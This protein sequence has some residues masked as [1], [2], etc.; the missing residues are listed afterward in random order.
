MNILD[1]K[2]VDDKPMDIHIKERI[3]IHKVEPK[4]ASIKNGRFSFSRKASLIESPIVKK[5]GTIKLAG[6]AGAKKVTEQVDG[7]EEIQQASMIAYTGAKPVS[8]AASKGAELVRKKA[9]AEKKR[10]IKKV[11]AEK[12]VAK[13]ATKKAA[14]ETTKAV[15]K[16]VAK[17]TAKTTAKAGATVA[18]TVAGTA[19][20]GAGGVAIG[21]VVGEAVG[22]KMD[23]EDTKR[24]S[25]FRKIKFFLGKMKAENEQQD[26]LLKLAKDLFLMKFALKAKYFAKTIFGL[27][28]SFGGTLALII[29]PIILIIALAYNSPLA[30][31]F[32]PLQEGDTVMTVTSAYVADFNQEVNALANMHAGHD[33]GEVV[34][35]DYEGISSTPSNY[36]DILA[37][38]MVKHGNGDTATLINDTT[39]DW[40]KEVVENMCSY[41]TS[42]G[43]STVENEDGTTST[44][45]VLNVNVSLKNYRDMIS[46]YGFD[47]DEVKTLETLMGSECLAI[48]GYT[49]VSGSVTSKSSL[50]AEEIAEILSEITEPTQRTVCS[51][52]L[53]KVGYPYSQAYRDTGDYY[54]CS[55]LAYYSWRAAGVNISY[56][57]S[58]TAAAEGQGLEAAGKTVG[59]S[60]M[61]PGDLIFFSYTRNGR[62]KNISHVAIYVGNGKVV[63][64]KNERYGVVYGDV[65]NTNCIVLIGRPQ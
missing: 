29:V 49:D 53:S 58:T 59:F 6:A 15:S 43:T 22:V 4:K 38:Y 13:K 24:A 44:V 16:K 12:K 42:S 47:S 23:V 63:E 19:A 62:Y 21:T 61:Q 64:A 20:T 37:V 39:K 60:E 18:G 54:D 11:D 56:G 32:P 3:K 45:S 9:L 7:G 41:T 17:K 8:D 2:K 27:L 57:G 52:A 46:V 25:R 55:S 30:I 48:L 26:S 35:V 65:P 34:Y 51:F 33:V 28:M 1:I 50:T 10:R 5:K 31:L 36:Y 14:K 40:I